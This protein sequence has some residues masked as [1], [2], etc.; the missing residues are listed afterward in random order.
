[1]DFN[2]NHFD[3]PKGFFRDDSQPPRSKAYDGAIHYKYKGVPL[4]RFIFGIPS[5]VKGDPVSN[6]AYH[7]LFSFFRDYFS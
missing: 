6:F 5:K 1:L 4:N 2:F 3:L 7:N